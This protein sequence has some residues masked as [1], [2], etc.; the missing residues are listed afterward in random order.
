MA[1]ILIQPHPPPHPFPPPLSLPLTRDIQ[2]ILKAQ[3][4]AGRKQLL[5][6]VARER[7]GMSGKCVEIEGGKMEFITNIR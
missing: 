2:E 6:K 7:Y 3:R 4:L 1:G 5:L